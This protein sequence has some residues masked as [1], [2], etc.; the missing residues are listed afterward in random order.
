MSA[1]P[2]ARPSLASQLSQLTFGFSRISIRQG[3]YKARFRKPKP[4]LT[5]YTEDH[6]E[7]IWVF[8]EVRS[9]QIVYSHSNV[10]NAHKALKQLPFAGKKT[11]PAKIRK[12][13]WDVLAVVQFPRGQGEVGRS[14]FA[15]LR[16]F[17]RRHELEWNDDMYF[18]TRPD[19]NRRVLSRQER[20]KKIHEQLPNAVADIAAVLAGAGKSNKMWLEAPAEAKETTAEAVEG[21]GVAEGNAAK[22][23]AAEGPKLCAATVFWS[24][25]VFRFHAKEW[26]PNVTHGLLDDKA[27]NW[28]VDK[29]D[30]TNID[31]SVPVMAPAGGNP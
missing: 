5:G 11:K 4:E 31:D 27:K 20:G 14:V 16:E 3:H 30:V 26:S 24:N 28:A 18:E 12:D 17:R 25:T 29:V 21:E 1:V 7:K 10:M 2:L 22:G 8:H 15:K 13:L 6:G 9:K 19:G 23:T